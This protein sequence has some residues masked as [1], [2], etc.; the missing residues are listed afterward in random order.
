MTIY[1]GHYYFPIQLQL[2]PK[3]RNIFVSKALEYV[4]FH[5]TYV[6]YSDTSHL[7]GMTRQNLLETLF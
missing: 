2:Y 7:N 4:I 1:F 5:S 6:N 3:L